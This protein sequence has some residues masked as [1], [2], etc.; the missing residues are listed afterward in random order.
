MK[1][2]F[3]ALAIFLLLTTNES[4]AFEMS[5]NEKNCMTQALYHE[6]RGEPERGIFAVASVIMNRTL[7]GNFPDDICGV[8]KQRGQ[9]TYD[10]KAKVRE[11]NSFYKVRSVVNA[12]EEGFEPIHPFLYFHRVDVVGQCTTKR[13]RIRIGHH[14]FCG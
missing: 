8:V 10:H 4:K 13:N 7:E 2:F 14:Y 12:I 1:Y 6:A 5:E 3:V 11:W 9:F